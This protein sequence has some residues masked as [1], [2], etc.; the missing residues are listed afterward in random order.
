MQDEIEKIENDMQKS[1]KPFGVSI[2][3]KT[4]KSANYAYNWD[5]V[6]RLHDNLALFNRLLNEVKDIGLI[7]KKNGVSIIEFNH[8][9]WDE[10]TSNRINMEVQLNSAK[11]NAKRSIDIHFNELI[12]KKNKA[13]FYETLLGIKGI[14][15]D[16]F[17]IEV[18]K[19]E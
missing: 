2:S 8:H 18:I 16:D 5:A 10:V 19:L 3:I 11:N 12:Q 9:T 17:D 15:T 14:D 4:G 1:F 7:M 6:Q 13:V